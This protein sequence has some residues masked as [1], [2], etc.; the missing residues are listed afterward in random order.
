MSLWTYRRSSAFKRPSD[1]VLRWSDLT[2]PRAELA[3]STDAV[4]TGVTSSS[5][6][7][8]EPGPTL[9]DMV[10]TGFQIPSSPYQQGLGLVRG[11]SFRTCRTFGNKSSCPET[12][13]FFLFSFFF[14]FFFFAVTAGRASPPPPPG[15]ATALGWRWK[16]QET[17]DIGPGVE[18]RRKASVDRNDC[19]WCVCVMT[20][21]QV[22]QGNQNKM[23]KLP[24][25]SVSATTFPTALCLYYA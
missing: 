15:S 18:W 19:V 14:F 24:R 6:S 17:S 16:P 25:T 12:I 20:R 8:L 10:T 4:V 21:C 1:I 23:A 7:S 2:N 22:A 11:Y 3:R 9:V 5:F 13:V